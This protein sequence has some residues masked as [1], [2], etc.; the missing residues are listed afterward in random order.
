MK[1]VVKIGRLVLVV[2]LVAIFS[3]F[4]TYIKL[5]KD[6]LNS[7]ANSKLYDLTDIIEALEYLDTTENNDPTLREKLETSL[8]SNLVA[9]NIINPKLSDLQGTPIA[10]LCRSIV[11]KRKNGI[12][13]NGIGK[14][15]DKKLP[16]LATK[17]LDNIEPELQEYIK[18]NQ[19]LST[20]KCKILN[21]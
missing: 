8:V 5:S 9:V 12:G 4:I 10:S 19:H 14:N 20:G 21:K 15:K 1:K 16:Q 2:L 18:S 11:Y 13:I 6:N 3:S 17:Y 7:K